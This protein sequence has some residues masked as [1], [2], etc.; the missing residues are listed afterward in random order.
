MKTSKTMKLIKVVAGGCLIAS[1]LVLGQNARAVVMGDA[2]YVGEID[3]GAPASAAAEAGYINFLTTLAIN[4]VV[5]NVVGD[6]Q[7][8]NR[9]GSTLNPPAA[10]DFPAAAAAG[11]VKVD[12]PPADGVIDASGFQYILGKYGGFSWVWYSPTGFSATESVPLR[13]E[14]GLSHISL[15]NG[16]SVPDAGASLVLFGAGLVGVGLMRRRISK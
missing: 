5:N 7:M 6:G 12:P 1:V 8:Y 2:N 10:G 16:I 14:T 13:G 11:A 9:I 4:D 3:P 15:Y